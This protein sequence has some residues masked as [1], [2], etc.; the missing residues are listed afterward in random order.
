MGD[1]MRLVVVVECKDFSAP[2]VKI[3]NAYQLSLF[4][5]TVDL[6]MAALLRVVVVVVVIDGEV[7]GKIS[8]L[9]YFLS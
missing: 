6:T 4:N 9:N 8:S 3:K 2:T 1:M 5:S 7:R